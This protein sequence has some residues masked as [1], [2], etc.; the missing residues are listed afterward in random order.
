M[1]WIIRSFVCCSA[2]GCGK[3]ES[4]KTTTEVSSEANTKEASAQVFAMDTYMNL[5]AYGKNAQKGS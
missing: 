5:K 3:K 1:H 2:V 4:I